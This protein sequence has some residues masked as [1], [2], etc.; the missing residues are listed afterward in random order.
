MTESKTNY[1]YGNKVAQVTPAEGVQGMLIRLGGGGFAFRVYTDNGEFI[2]YDIRHDDLSIT[3]DKDALAS[4][5]R[6]G[7][8]DILDH[9]PQVLGLKKAAE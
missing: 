8:H 2:D 6:I 9:S 3:I 5:Y 4:F 1:Y 7:E